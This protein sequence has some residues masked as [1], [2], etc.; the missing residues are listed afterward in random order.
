MTFFGQ[1]EKRKRKEALPSLCVEEPEISTVNIVPVFTYLLPLQP[2]RTMEKI[3]PKTWQLLIIS[4][5]ME[6]VDSVR[7]N[8]LLVIQ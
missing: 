2:A 6:D 7:L 1:Y 5:N 3:P 4:L 8:L